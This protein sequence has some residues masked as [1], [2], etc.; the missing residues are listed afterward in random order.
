MIDNKKHNS[1]QRIKKLVIILLSCAVLM[2][3]F[4]Y[5]LVPMYNVLCKQLGL[6]G[7]YDAVP[8]AASFTGVDAERTITV[9]FVTNNNANLPWKFYPFRRSVDIHPGQNTRIAFYAKNLTSNTMTVRAIPSIAPSIASKYLKKTECFCFAKQTLKSGE[10]MNMPVLFHVDKDL[11]KNINT[12]TL[13]YTLFD[14]TGEPSSSNA[15]PTGKLT[16]N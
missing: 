7:K 12:I 6:N 4:G 3:G 11:P 10:A 15:G 9:Q 5:A 14:V 1:P 8:Q 16:A 13:A 2:F